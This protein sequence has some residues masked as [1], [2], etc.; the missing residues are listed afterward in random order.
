MIIIYPNGGLGNQLFQYAAGRAL[1]IQRSVE[2]L[3]DPW[4]Y[5][6]NAESGTRPFLLHKLGL[7][8]RFTSYSGGQLKSTSCV[9]QRALR[10][11]GRPL[12]RQHVR[13][14][15]D[16]KEEEFFS[17]S[18]NAVLTGYFQSLTYFGRHLNYIVGDID[19]SRIAS[20]EALHIAAEHG[21]DNYC[22]IQVRR[23][24]F[25]G[26]QLFDIIDFQSYYR[27]AISSIR[28]SLGITKYFVFSD[29]PEWCETQA[30]F[31]GMMVH[32]AESAG[33]AMFLMSK[34]GA[35]IIAN[36]SYGWWAAVL[37]QRIKSGIV[38]APSQW[39][40]GLRTSEARLNF[41]SWILI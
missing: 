8:A 32:R 6:N 15:C 33:D 9:Y 21:L 26:N 16:M 3:I 25:V 12:L 38:I 13:D 14:R 10:K 2:L 5:G 37:S 40:K 1:S 19:L 23:G 27:S 20:D 29:E 41:E 7:P 34:C 17:S 11:L 35:H 30:I 36:S 24:D 18:S 31:N 28:Y 4:H 22:A 39:L